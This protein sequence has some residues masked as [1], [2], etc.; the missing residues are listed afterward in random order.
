[1]NPN[2]LNMSNQSAE[3]L[4]ELLRKEKESKIEPDPDINAYMKVRIKKSFWIDL[5]D[6][7]YQHSICETIRDDLWKKSP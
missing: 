5:S 6:L 2:I 1:M 7:T 3:M 4:T